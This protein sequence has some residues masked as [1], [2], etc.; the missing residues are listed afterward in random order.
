MYKFQIAQKEIKRIREC[1]EKPDGIIAFPT[2][3]VW[4]IGC[5]VEN[6]LAVDKIYSIK[7]RSSIKP[8]ILLGSK[9]SDL[10]PYVSQ[11]PEI[12]WN[13]IDNYMPGAVTLILP[14]SEKAPSYLTSGGNTIGIRIPD[15]P[16]FL[17]MLENAVDSHVLA[18]TSAN[19]SG[20]KAGLS[21]FEV[22]ESLGSKI[23]YVMDD[24]G[25][26]PKGVESTVVL[27]DSSGCI[28]I[29]RQGTVKI[30]I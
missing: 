15:C 16:V 22:E 3:T 26:I 24:Y 23:N 18:T 11:I 10:V 1:L 2:D 5:L 30:E 8:L 7:G 28:K 20:E 12:A 14:K 13:I 6:K 29:L 27:V 9:I 21:K 25:F 4:G 19:I 17:S